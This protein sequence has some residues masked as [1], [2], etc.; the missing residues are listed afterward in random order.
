MAVLLSVLAFF[1]AFVAVWC[2]A[3]VQNRV[4]R[5]NKEFVNSQVQAFQSTLAENAKSVTDLTRRLIELERE[6]REF[7][8]TRDQ[9]AE[10]LSSLEERT[11][12]L[13]T[14]LVE[15]RKRSAA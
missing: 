1:V 13:R 15:D 6:V 9:D 12:E 10:I 14:R 3:A 4:D 8:S 2:V 7:R 11:G 5:Q